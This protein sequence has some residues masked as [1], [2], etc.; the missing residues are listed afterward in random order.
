LQRFR[1]A[2]QNFH[3]HI[4]VLELIYGVAFAPVALACTRKWFRTLGAFTV[5]IPYSHWSDMVAVLAGIGF[6]TLTGN[7]YQMTLPETLDG[8][9][10]RSA[11]LR[12]VVPKT[13]KA[14]STLKLC[15]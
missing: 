4:Q 8:E 15:S 10:I 2:D 11:L 12:L 1:A 3:K 6:L 13:T 9:S 14:A 5:K 7:R